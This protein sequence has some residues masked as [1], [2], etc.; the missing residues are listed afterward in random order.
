V[1]HS[2]SESPSANAS[3]PPA[4]FDAGSQRFRAGTGGTSVLGNGRTQNVA[5]FDGAGQTQR[6]GACPQPFVRECVWCG[7]RDFEPSLSL[8]KSH[9]ADHSGLHLERS[10]ISAGFQST[11]SR[12]RARP[13]QRMIPGQDDNSETKSRPHGNDDTL[14]GNLAFTQNGAEISNLVGRHFGLKEN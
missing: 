6:L 1:F 5:R 7:R 10:A 14:Y 3:N 11:R 9:R 13:L 4:F 8:R 12:F 2:A